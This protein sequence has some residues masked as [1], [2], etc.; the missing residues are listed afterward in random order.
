MNMLNR[1]SI[2]S[3]FTF[4]VGRHERHRIIIIHPPSLDVFIALLPYYPNRNF[5]FA[6]DMPAATA[7]L[8]TGIHLWQVSF[9]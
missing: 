7:H 8:A 1:F 2:V 6:L 9:F 3:P 4:S 5:I